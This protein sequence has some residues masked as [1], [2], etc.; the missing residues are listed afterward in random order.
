MAKNQRVLEIILFF[1]F[2]ALSIHN[3]SRSIY[4]GDTGILVSAAFVGG[5]PHPPGYPLFTLI[6]FILTRFT[7]LTHASPAFLVGLIS[8]IASSLAILFYFRISLKLTKN[9][10]VAVISTLTLM[11]MY[12]F[13]FFAEIPEVFALNNF[14]VFL[15]IYLAIRYSEVKTKKSLYT[16]VFFTGLSLTNHLTI[17]LIFP[18]LLLITFSQL[19]NAVSKEKSVIVPVILTGLLGLTPYLYIVASSLAHPAIDWANIDSVRSF[20]S[21][22]LR[23]RYGTFKAGYFDDPGVGDR[24]LIAYQY[25]LTLL[26]QLTIPV[27]FLCTISSIIYLIKRNRVGISFLLA[28]I[29][30]GPLFLLYA[31]F[32]LDNTFKLGIVERFMSMSSV[33]F[34]LLLPLGLQSF[35]TTLGRYFSRPIYT[36]LFIGIFL[37]IPLQLF[38]FNF[39]KTN[40]SDVWLGDRLGENYLKILPKNSILLLASDTSLF[41]TLY[42]R[43]ARGIRKDVTVINAIDPRAINVGLKK[44]DTE[45]TLPPASDKDQTIP[46]LGNIN[47]IDRTHPVFSEFAYKGIPGVTW[48][49]YGLV[50]ELRRSDE[51]KLSHSEFAKRTKELWNRLSTPLYKNN[52]SLGARNLSIASVF[53]TYSW[54]LWHTG[55]FFVS[56]YK[57]TAGYSEYMLQAI[58]VYPDFHPALASLASYSLTVAGD[59]KTALLDYQQAIDKDPLN[60]TYYERMAIAQRQCHT[61]KRTMEALKQRYQKLFHKPLPIK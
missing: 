39:P 10:L 59:C 8:S 14:F 61:D 4:A 5:V 46:M 18:A 31:G 42:I 27:I 47:Y 34:L 19:K 53:N 49:P 51:K 37:L 21:F 7:S 32:P 22:V 38:I 24:L 17:V 43:H 6:G 48:V 3:L 35:G 56:E 52:T 23:E 30:S 54:A 41:D 16:L 13:W 29:L 50:Y 40:L 26:S 12:L 58:R 55:Q 60:K 57:D 25:S 44:L 45:I 2:L 9:I 15:L 33:I 36:S 20:I 11:T 28:F 1:S